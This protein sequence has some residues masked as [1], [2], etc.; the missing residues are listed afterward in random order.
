M[1]RSSPD[2]SG[3]SVGAL[4]YADLEMND[5]PNDREME[6]RIR[7][8]RQGPPGPFEVSFVAELTQAYRAGLED[9][10]TV[11]DIAMRDNPE[12]LFRF[13]G[14]TNRLRSLVSPGEGGLLATE[15]EC[16]ALLGEEG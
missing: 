12:L 8:G 6:S 10:I 9:I 16:R 1:E 14:L 15:Q 3:H 4:K 11:L 5:R 2:G 7:P 13:A